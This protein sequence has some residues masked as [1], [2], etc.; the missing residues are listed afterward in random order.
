MAHADSL[1]EICGG[2]ACCIGKL[3]HLGISRAPGKSTLS[4]ANKNWPAELYEELFWTMVKRFRE[5]GGLG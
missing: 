4:S 1:R 5:N 2:L 3:K